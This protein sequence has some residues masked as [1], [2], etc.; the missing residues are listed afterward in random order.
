MY[1]VIIIFSDPY[2]PCPPALPLKGKG[3]K[4]QAEGREAADMRFSAFCLSE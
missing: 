3:E 1:F 4:R 2:D